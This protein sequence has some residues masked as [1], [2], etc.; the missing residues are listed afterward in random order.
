MR[1]SATIVRR[2][3]PMVTVG[4]MSLALIAPADGQDRMVLGPD[5]FKG[6]KSG[7]W[8]REPLGRSIATTNLARF[9]SL[10]NPEKV[11]SSVKTLLAIRREPLM[12]A[13]L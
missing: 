8:R 4:M 5:Q 2:I 12:K 11:Q 6:D 1:N 13:C 3:M 7:M 9:R 10:L